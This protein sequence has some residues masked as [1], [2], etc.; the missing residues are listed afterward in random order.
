MRNFIESGRSGR[1]TQKLREKYRSRFKDGPTR[2]GSRS[3]QRFRRNRQF[4]AK[5]F[6]TFVLW[7]A[8]A[9]MLVPMGRSLWRVAQAH[10]SERP[11]AVQLALP[12]IAG[13]ALVFCVLRARS[14]WREL[15][16]LRQEQ[17]ELIRRMREDLQG[18]EG[19][20]PS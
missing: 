2:S 12:A 6:T 11:L 5:E 15:R 17:R 9:V 20:D 4:Q 10:L 16:E 14:S 19:V 13:V 18:D 1:R 8:I 7:L 3:I